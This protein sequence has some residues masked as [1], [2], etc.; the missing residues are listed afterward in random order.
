MSG[1]EQQ[2]ESPV[3]SSAIQRHLP[4]FKYQSRAW[5]LAAKPSLQQ[6]SH[7]RDTHGNTD[8]SRTSV[9]IAA[10]NPSGLILSSPFISSSRGSN[11]A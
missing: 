7:A 11:S 8:P 9:F 6:R 4:N 5:V 3:A 2:D 1:P 10:C